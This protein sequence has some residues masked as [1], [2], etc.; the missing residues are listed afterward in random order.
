[1][2]NWPTTADVASWLEIVR[3]VEPLFGPMPD[4]ETTLFRKIDQQAALCV[5]S[6]NQ[7]GSVFVLGGILLGGAP[8]RGQIRWLA[9]RSSARGIGIGRCLVEEAIKR[10]AASNSISLEAFREENIEG[11]PARRLYERLGFLPG[12]LIEVG[13]L[14]RQR[15]TLTL[16]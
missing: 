4:F 16:A 6:D 5:R 2:P 3:E 1:M 15:Y 9:V 10:L 12:P 11:R 14:P 8:P 7:H 13:G